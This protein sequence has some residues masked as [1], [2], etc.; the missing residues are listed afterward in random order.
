MKSLDILVNMLDNG[1][2]SFER[3]A[4]IFIQIFAFVFWQGQS[5]S[6]MDIL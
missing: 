6:E 5:F 4:I 2:G 1:Q 3:P